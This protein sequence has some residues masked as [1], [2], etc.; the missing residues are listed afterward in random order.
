MTGVRFNNMVRTATGEKRLETSSSAGNLQKLSRRLV[1][2]DRKEPISP[3]RN[4]S[5]SLDWG[6]ARSV[7]LFSSSSEESSMDVMTGLSASPSAPAYLSNKDSSDFGYS[8]KIM[9]DI[10]LLSNSQKK[11]SMSIDVPD[12]QASRRRSDK[13]A[14]CDIT[15]L[16]DAVEQQDIDLAKFILET[17]AVDINS[18]NGENLSVLDIAVMTNNIPMAKILLSRGAKESPMFQRGD[19]RLQKLEMLVTEAEKRV[20]DLTAIVLTGS[21]GNANISP[22]QLR[23]NEKLL[24]H[25]EFRHRLLKRMKA[26]YDHA[27][28]PEPPTN[29]RLEVASNSSLLVTFAEPQSHNAA[30][31]TKYKVEWSCWETFTPLTGEAI[32]EDLAHLEYEIKNLNKGNMY[33]VR[34]CAWNVKGLGPYCQSEPACAAPSC[35]R[36]V[37]GIP[38][39]LEGKVASLYTLYHQVK[40]SR[41]P[42][43]A[44]MKDILNR[45]AESPMQKKRISIKNLFV[46]TPKFQ[47]TVKRGVYMACL[48]YNEDRILVTSEEQLPIIEVDETFSAPSI[49]NDL[50]WLLKVSCM[51]EEVKVLKQDM[52]R[53]SSAG[54]TFR[55]KLLQAIISLQSGLGVTDLGQFFH[56]PVRDNSSSIIFTVVNQIRDPKLVTLGS[57]KWVTFG[58]LA[59]RQ[60]LSSV[61]SADAHSLLITSV[62]EMILYNQVSGVA[63]PRGLYLGYVK[64][65]ASV[66]VLRVMVPNKTPNCVPHVKIRDM[67]N[68]SKEEWEWLLK[69]DSHK[70]TITMTTTQK[71]FQQLLVDATKK[72][73]SQLELSEEM[74]A[75]HRVYDLE[76]L[77]LS[78]SVTMILILPSMEDI[79]IVPGHSDILAKRADYSFL[80]V[81]IFESIHMHAYLPEFFSLYARLSAI[82]EMDGVLAQQGHRE[83][84]SSEELSKAKEQVEVTAHLQQNLDRIWKCARW[85]R[86]I[87]TYAR[88]RERKAGIHLSHILHASTSNHSIASTSHDSKLKLT[89]LSNGGFSNNNNNNH[90]TATQCSQNKT[91]SISVG[92]DLRRIAK[93]YDPNEENP[94]SADSI[95]IGGGH[96]DPC[97]NKTNSSSSAPTTPTSHQS[98]RPHLSPSSSV[99]SA[100]TST[101]SSITESATESTPVQ[102]PSFAIIKVHALYD[103]GLNRSVN[104]K[105]HITEQTTSRDIVNLV[106]RHLN[107]V[108]QNKGKGI[109]AYSEEALSNFCLVLKYQGHEKILKDDFKLMQLK[110]QLLRAKICVMMMEAM[111]S[112]EEL[113][114]ATVV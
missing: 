15:A 35:W 90:F 9:K 11:K 31:V 111:F 6:D 94:H 26:G 43:A 60:S 56:R 16:F 69:S 98:P 93:F 72:L 79:C 36:E 106:V 57:S 76:V 7:K 23:E 84:F 83:A 91:N 110:G 34:V 50:Y 48:F 108:V 103:T 53:T 75:S 28:P 64:L 81:Q 2:R 42:E 107:S 102:D 82:V 59:R 29:V 32:I 88:N 87:T 74:L 51:W 67:P 10:R 20:I 62:P 68:V 78:P 99:S 97:P 86:D 73:F 21:S 46:S 1:L 89:R 92:K 5:I 3:S 37:D 8:P 52:E 112:E 101:S 85:I 14:L 100:S 109:L 13:R 104:I 12:G 45:G 61:D 66:E 44:E 17:N 41:P 105:L 27:K 19:C 63:L 95:S 71:N 113:G 47:K 70:H 58:K 25:W 54:S 65:Q 18:L 22:A 38:S 40:K 30:V 39:R 80:P 96:R 77:E 114:Q 55:C 33:Y 49:Q 4:R 24:S